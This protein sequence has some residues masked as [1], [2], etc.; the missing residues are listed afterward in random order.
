MVSLSTVCFIFSFFCFLATYYYAFL[1]SVDRK[2]KKSD[3][4][5]WYSVYECGYMV[6]RHVVNSSGDTFLNLLVYYVVLDLEVALVVNL[7]LEGIWFK[8]L[9]S[10]MLFIILLIAGLGIEVYSGYLS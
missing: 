3:A 1:W 4:R 2:I 6:G 5:L 8:G 7:S 9:E 10:F